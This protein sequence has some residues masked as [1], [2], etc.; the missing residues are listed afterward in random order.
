MIREKAG[1]SLDAVA[2][3]LRI[4]EKASVHRWEKG[5]RAISGPVSILMELLEAGELPSRY[6]EHGSDQ[7]AACSKLGEEQ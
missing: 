5:Q 4:R 7:P 6:L 2:R 3:V 1:L